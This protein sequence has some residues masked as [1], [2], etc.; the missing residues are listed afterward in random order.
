MTANEEQNSFDKTV[1]MMA[2]MGADALLLS[3][4]EPQ[5]GMVVGEPF[6]TK[7]NRSWSMSMIS[8]LDEA[9]R[10]KYPKVCDPEDK[11]LV[12]ALEKAYNQQGDKNNVR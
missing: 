7:T 4:Y 10:C 12:E 9:I 3:N 6:D 8:S 2:N 5:Y 11:E 1:E